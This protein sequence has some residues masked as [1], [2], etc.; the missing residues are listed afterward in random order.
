[1]NH[2][3]GC[4]HILLDHHLACLAATVIRCSDV[5]V[6]LHLTNTPLTMD[7]YVFVVLSPSSA[8]VL[9]LIFF[10]VDFFIYNFLVFWYQLIFFHTF[11][12]RHKE[13]YIGTIYF[14]YCRFHSFWLYRG[15]EGQQSTVWWI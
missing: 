1:M 4:H 10:I 13:Y 2:L 15:G 6:F 8:N 3:N 12:G 11:F 14:H 7:L 5:L 9:I